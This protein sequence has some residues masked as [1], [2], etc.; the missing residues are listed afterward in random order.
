M[1]D[2]A[3]ALRSNAPERARP[4]CADWERVQAEGVEVASGQGRQF[5]AVENVFVD[6]FR[7][8][9]AA[10]PGDQIPSDPLDVCEACLDRQRHRPSAGT[11]R[12]V[13]PAPSGTAE[14]EPRISPESG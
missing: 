7:R 1:E 14:P 12:S 11:G 13:S 9:D 8:A 10:G 2:R 4:A 6:Q 3:A 5:A